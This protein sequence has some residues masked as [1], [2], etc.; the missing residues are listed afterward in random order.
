[1][2]PQLLHTIGR[3][4]IPF[5]EWGYL[6]LIAILIQAVAAGALLIL[7]PL[8]S[9][10]KQHT[11]LTTR[12]NDASGL[13]TGGKNAVK[14]RTCGYF[15]SLGI[16]FMFIEMAFIQKFLL[17]LSHP[18]YAVG[19]ALYAFL[20]FAGLGEPLLYADVGH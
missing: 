8:L 14:W 2:L 6:L 13:S 12:V 16:G 15:L 20:V 17:L 9:L 3:N 18:I 10:R 1:M 5:I 19:V 11:S 7:L 4:A